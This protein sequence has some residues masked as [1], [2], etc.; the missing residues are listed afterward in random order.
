MVPP[1]GPRS[2]PAPKGVSIET[3]KAA[4]GISPYTAG[5]RTHDKLAPSSCLLKKGGEPD[6]MTNGRSIP[7][8]WE[9]ASPA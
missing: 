8:V 5:S 3:T 1:P 6:I 7:A 4:Q 9:G 2:T